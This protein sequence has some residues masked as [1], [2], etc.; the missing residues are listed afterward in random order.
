MKSADS[1]KGDGGA[2]KFKMD[3]PREICQ[4]SVL[5]GIFGRSTLEPI[6]KEIK[7]GRFAKLID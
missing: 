3:V 6:C 4:T 5:M 1:K 2:C 7:M